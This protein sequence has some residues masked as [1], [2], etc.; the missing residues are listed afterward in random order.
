MSHNNIENIIFDLGGVIINLD[1]EKTFLNFSRVFNKKIDSEIL[2]DHDKFGFFREYEVGNI[3]DDEFRGEIKKLSDEPIEDKLI[4]DAWI[5][6][7]QDI[8]ANR[9]KWI[10]EATQKY[11]CVVLSNTN[12]IHVNHF[13]AYFNQVTPYGYPGDVFQQLFYSHEIGERKPNAAAFQR[14]LDDTGFDPEKTVL[15]DDLKENLV[16]ASQLGIKKEY[17]ERN[18]LREEQLLNINNG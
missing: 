13:E 6:M 5:A 8:P 17:V 14:V 11:N 12:H 2:A 1:F 18:N 3:E 15:F 10:Y 7:L 4:D 16:A 9:I